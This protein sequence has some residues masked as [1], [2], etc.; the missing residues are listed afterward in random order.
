MATYIEIDFEQNCVVSRHN[1][2][3]IPYDGQDTDS[4]WDIFGAN[5]V[6]KENSFDI[7]LEDDVTEMEGYLVYVIYS[8]GDSFSRHTDGGMAVVDLYKDRETA[9][10][11]AKRI[12]EHSEESRQNSH[13]PNY[14]EFSVNIPANNGKTV[15]FFCSWAGYF[16]RISSIKVLKIS[17]VEKY[18]TDF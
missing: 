17:V 18:Q 3:N 6:S 9:Q 2:P 7:V 11:V 8:T 13:D 4:S 16:E 1:N 10:K 12:R 15:R 5:I 14:D